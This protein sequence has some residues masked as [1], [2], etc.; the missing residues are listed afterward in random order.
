MT[1][2]AFRHERRGHPTRLDVSIAAMRDAFATYRERREI[3]RRK[4]AVYLRT[5]RELQS[6]RPHE[7]SDLRIDPADFQAIARKQAGW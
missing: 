6:Y 5:L 2:I 3:Y 1:D 4:R 7:L